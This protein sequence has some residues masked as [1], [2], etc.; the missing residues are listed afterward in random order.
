MLPS[1]DPTILSRLTEG[2]SSPTTLEFVAEEEIEARSILSFLETKKEELKTINQTNGHPIL[3][4]LYN[5]LKLSKRG[6]RGISKAK[7]I[8]LDNPL[9]MPPD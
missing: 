4:A 6:V 1:P 8:E 5:H 2:G 9:D 3:V 7:L